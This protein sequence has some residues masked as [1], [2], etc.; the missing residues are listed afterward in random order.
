MLTSRDGGHTEAVYTVDFSPDGL[1]IASGSRD[2][3][4]KVWDAV[5]FT[6]LGTLREH[7]PAVYCLDFSPDGFRLA[8]GGGDT[9]IKI[10]SMYF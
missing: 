5:N 1:Y 4:T 9:K 10:W 3:T 2:N 7:D 6:L 8:T